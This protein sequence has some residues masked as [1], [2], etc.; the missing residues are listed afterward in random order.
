MTE[1]EKC[2]EQVYEEGEP[3][4]LLDARQ[5][6]AEAF[7]AQCRLQIS[8]KLD[9]HYYGGVARVL[10]LGKE[11]TQ[12]EQTIRQLSWAFD[13]DLRLLRIVPTA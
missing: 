5:A 2:G 10:Y 11:R 7:V 9:W 8:G 6:I 13:G 1:K 4:A 12:A 3:I